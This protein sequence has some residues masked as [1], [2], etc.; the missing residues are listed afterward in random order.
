MRK[1][2]V[3]LCTILLF[4]IVPAITAAV[5]LLLTW[6]PNSEADLAGYRIYIASQAGGPY[7]QAGLAPTS[8]A[9]A[10]SYDVPAGSERMYYFVITAYDNAGNESG[11]SNEAGIYIDNVMPGNP[12]GLQITIIIT[13]PAR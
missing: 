12:M 3:L 13:L 10:F 11:Y 9:P 4:L 6:A 8:L 7:M 2:L 5:Q 1:I